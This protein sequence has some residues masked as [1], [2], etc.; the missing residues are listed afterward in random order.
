MDRNNNI[1]ADIKYMNKSIPFDFLDRSKAVSLSW[2]V[3]SL[4][5]SNLVI[6]KPPTTPRKN[7]VVIGSSNIGPVSML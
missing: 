2:Q 6:R 4:N 7:A 1:K 5:T 3:V